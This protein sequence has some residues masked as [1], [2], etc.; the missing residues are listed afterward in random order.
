MQYY[1]YHHGIKGQKWGIRRFQ[2]TDGSLTP[3]GRKRYADNLSESK[4]RYKTAKKEYSRAY[5][6]YSFVPTPKNYQK[7]VDSAEN[8]KSTKSDYKMAKLDY[9]VGKAKDAGTLMPDDQKSKHRLAVEEKYRQKG[10]TDEQAAIAA[11]DRIRTEKVLVATAALT[12]TACAAYAVNR[13]IKD[14]A[15]QMIKSGDILQRIEMKNTEGKLHDTFYVSKGDRDNKRYEGLLGLTRKAQ[16]GEAYLMKLQANS[17]IKVA[18]KDKATKVFE[19]LYKNDSD[20][21]ESVKNSV[22]KHFSGKNSVDTDNLSS[23]NIKK[24]YE[25][26]NSNLIELRETGSG[27]DT[28]FYGKL[29]SLGYGAVQDINDM[30]FSG[31]NA[32][33]PLIV[34]DNSKN[35]IMVKSVKEL[36]NE[37]EILKKGVIEAGKG[38]VEN[39]GKKLMTTPYVPVA[40]TGAAASMYVSDVGGRNFINQYRKDHPNSKLT[41]SEIFKFYEKK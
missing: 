18:S 22:S 15:D 5:N 11:G 14:K 6:K 13:N 38:S 16:G 3:A 25:N 20:F 30:K 28:K 39:M 23:K 36:T 10:Y 8:V 17:D 35:N 31:Y 26:F 24:M 29:K 2:N 33:N 7:L 32:K 40:A 12:V 4:S 27:A 19:D 37:K 34:F 41:N 21:R 1:L 9:K